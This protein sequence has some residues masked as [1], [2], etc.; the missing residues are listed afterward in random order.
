LV[1]KNKTIL[2][3]GGAGY[4]GSHACKALARY[5]YNPVA[6]DN[7]STGHAW[8]VKWGDLEECDLR[9]REKIATIFERHKPVAVMH[10]AAHSYVGESVENPGKYYN[11]NVIGTLTLL[12]VMR[13]QGIDMLVFSSTCATYGDPVSIPMNEAHP[14]E[15]VNPYGFG[16]LA[17]E[18]MMVDYGKAYGLKF[19]SLRYFNAAGADPEAEIGEAHQP[20]THIIPLVLDVAAGKRQNISIFGTDYDTPDGTCIRDYIHVTDLADAHI[21]ALDYLLDGRDSRSVNLGNGEGFSVREVIEAARTITGHS[22]PAVETDRRPGDPA[23]LVSDSKL[24]SDLLGWQPKRAGIE[25][26]IED[27]WRWHQKLLN[28]NN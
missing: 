14:Q 27:A 15:P 17:A 18:R 1:A 3:T 23:R 12:E 10:F 2:V 20:E 8:S 26:Q 24:A 5:G 13:E 25:I 9:D 28:I 6:V 4:I 11:N 7:L 16:K 22:I 21:R 19:V